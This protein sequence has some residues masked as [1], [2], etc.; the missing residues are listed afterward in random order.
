M[1]E[2]LLREVWGQGFA[3]PTF[4]EELEVVTQRIVGEKHLSLRLKHQG[5]P[6]DGIWFGRVDPL[7]TKAHLAYRLQADEWQ[8]VK[9]VQFVIEA[10]AQD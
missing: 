2:T 8:G 9:R 7:P 5:Q 10:M 6:V 1:A 4:S 3:A